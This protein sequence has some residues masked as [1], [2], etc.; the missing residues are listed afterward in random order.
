MVV[1]VSSPNTPGL[2]TLQHGDALETLL[3]TLREAQTR[4][5]QSAG[6]RVPLLIKIAPDN[7]AEAMAAMGEAFI[8]HQMDGVIVGNT[9]LSRVGVEGLPHGNEAGGLSGAPLKPL[10]D[11]ALT[12]MVA[13]LGGKLPVIGVGGILSGEDAAEKQRLGASLVQIYS[14]LIYR[15]PGLVAEAVKAWR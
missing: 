2:R 13:A 1:N 11:Q 12:A 3:S 6:R 9:T 5:D 7:D 14:G 8:R 15:G 4:L 10:A